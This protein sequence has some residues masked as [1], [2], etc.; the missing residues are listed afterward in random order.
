ML[1][2]SNAL[3]NECLARPLRYYWHAEFLLV[4][5][6]K[7]DYNVITMATTTRIIRIG[8]SRGIRIPKTLLDEA[9]LTGEVILRAEKGRLVVKSSHRP[10]QGWREEAQRMHSRAEDRLL[11]PVTPTE[12]DS[13]EWTW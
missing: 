5:W 3:V 6:P 4:I 11:D 10:R 2:Q 12:F 1:E 9:E 7:S 8:N 13:K